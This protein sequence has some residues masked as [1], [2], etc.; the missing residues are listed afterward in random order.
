MATREP[1]FGVRMDRDGNVSL[2]RECRPRVVRRPADGPCPRRRKDGA[3]PVDGGRRT[4]RFVLHTRASSADV[5]SGPGDLRSEEDPGALRRE[6]SSLG[7]SGA[8]IGWHRAHPSL[9][10]VQEERESLRGMPAGGQIQQAH[11]PSR[12][13]RLTRRG[14]GSPRQRRLC[15]RAC[16][17]RW[18]F[19]S[20]QRGVVHRCVWC[21]RR[22][23]NQ[24]GTGTTCGDAASA[25]GDCDSSDS[26]NGMDSVGSGAS[27]HV[28]SNFSLSLIRTGGGQEA[29]SCMACP[30]RSP[31]SP[32]SWGLPFLLFSNLGVALMWARYL[33]DEW[34]DTDVEIMAHTVG[35]PLQYRCQVFG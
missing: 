1:S 11:E 2:R 34:D 33:D 16:A 25:G 32:L 18:G 24:K 3:R 21:P 35:V 31:S 15:R 27:H 10:R 8:S 7:G 28:L 29:R 22:G 23:T 19:A 20:A 26:P 9:P 13:H 12:L 6:S 4:S 14:D 5:V 30:A 17:S